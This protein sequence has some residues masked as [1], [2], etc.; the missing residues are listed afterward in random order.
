MKT[1]NSSASIAAPVSLVDK[2]TVI[3]DKAAVAVPIAKLR[4]LDCAVA[5]RVVH[6]GRR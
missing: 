2:P 5:S 6:V 3:G 1:G 4:Y